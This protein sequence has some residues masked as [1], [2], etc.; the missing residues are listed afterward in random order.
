MS[1]ERIDQNWTLL[2]I[3]RETKGEGILTIVLDGIVEG[4]W[5]IWREKLNLIGDV[6]KEA[7]AVWQQQLK[8]TVVNGTCLPPQLHVMMMYWNNLQSNKLQYKQ[9]YKNPDSISDCRWVYEITVSNVH[10]NVFSFSWS[11]SKKCKNVV[12]LCFIV[13]KTVQRILLTVTNR[14]FVKNSYSVLSSSK[15][16]SH[17]QYLSSHD[18]T[19]PPRGILPTNNFFSSML[20]PHTTHLMNILLRTWKYYYFKIQL[21]KINS[22]LKYYNRFKRNVTC[23]IETDV[24]DKAL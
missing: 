14:D 4:E 18:I 10:K 15:V 1:N 6:K 5:R 11:I 20:L 24:A 8:T 23:I 2:D 22:I 13:K 9:S 7:K 21:G 17:K 3:I 19:S 12:L 16:G